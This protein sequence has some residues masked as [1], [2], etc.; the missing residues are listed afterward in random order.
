MSWLRRVWQGIRRPSYFVGKDIEGNKF[1]EYPSVSDDPRR[2]KRVVEY[3]RGQDIL[4]YVS[5]GKRLPVQWSA[6]LTHTR[7][8]PPTLE[9]LQSDLERQR[10]VLFNAAVIEA[11][12]REERALQQIADSSQQGAPASGNVQDAS[13]FHTQDD[14]RKHVSLL[15]PHSELAPN[16]NSKHQKTLERSE[17]S[18][19]QHQRGPWIEISDKPQSWSP[20]MRQRGS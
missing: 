14:G 20:S 15:A 12:D 9:E 16:D 10:R 7:S 8:H 17:S 6:W 4:Q 3:T 11:R 2:T 18:N 1:Y 5:G 19:V 13:S